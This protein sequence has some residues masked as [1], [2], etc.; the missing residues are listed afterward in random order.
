MKKEELKRL[1][2]S[3]A[4]IDNIEDQQWILS[5]FKNIITESNYN[6]AKNILAMYNAKFTFKIDYSKDQFKFAYDQLN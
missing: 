5:L 3:L 6:N 1:I 4:Q 2:K